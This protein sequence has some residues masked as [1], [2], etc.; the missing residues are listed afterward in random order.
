AGWP[1]RQANPWLVA[2]AALITLVSY[3]VKAWA[4]QRLF[5]SDHRPAMLTL[6]AAGGAAAGGGIAPPGPRGG[7]PRGAGGPGCPRARARVGAVVLSLFSLGLLDSVALSPLA[8]VAAG[9]SRVG[10][11]LLVGLI[12]VALAGVGA[13]G[14]LVLLPRIARARWLERF[15]LARFVGEHAT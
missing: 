9:L 14:L 13:A 1:L 3:A 8:A 6:A 2:L 5:V 15:R 4:W 12:L 10:G 7:G 11:V